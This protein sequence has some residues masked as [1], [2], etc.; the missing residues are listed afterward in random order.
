MGGEAREYEYRPGWTTIVFGGG[1]FALCAAVIG[2]KAAHN[3][4]GLIINRIIELGPDGATS[5]YWVLTALSAGFVVLATFLAYHRVTCHQR[6][7]F[8][9]AAMTV[10]A[11]RWSREKKEIAYS[12]IVALSETTISGQRFLYVTH[13]GGKHTITA[14]MLPSKAAFA[15]I[16]EFL[17]AMVREAH[18][19]E[20]RHVEPG[21]AADSGGM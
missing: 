20:K 21:A 2:S 12:D 8:G 13:S 18:L 15:E 5:F 4:R 9:R 17:A 16:C 1:F 10:P 6:L 7:V 3:E 14:S 11:S 19:A